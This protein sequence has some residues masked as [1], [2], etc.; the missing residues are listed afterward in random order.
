MEGYSHLTSLFSLC[1]CLILCISEGMSLSW[2]A[3]SSFR[4]SMYATTCTHSQVYKLDTCTIYESV[5][6]ELLS[7][8]RLAR[9]GE[10]NKF[11]VECCEAHHHYSRCYAFGL[12]T[13]SHYEEYYLTQNVWS[14]VYMYYLQIPHPHPLSSVRHIVNQKSYCHIQSVSGSAGGGAWQCVPQSYTHKYHSS[15]TESGPLTVLPLPRALLSA[16]RSPTGGWSAKGSLLLVIH[17]LYITDLRTCSFL[18]R[19]CH[20]PVFDCLW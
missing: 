16:L 4:S 1:S 8:W 3:S 5:L 14:S 10:W 20:H 18:P 7:D 2:R 13:S 15:G 6:R 17:T 12:W 11:N 19:P 9:Y